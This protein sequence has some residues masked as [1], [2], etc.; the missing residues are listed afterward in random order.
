MTN[1]SNTKAHGNLNSHSKHS[2]HIDLNV[3]VNSHDQNCKLGSVQPDI[4]SRSTRSHAG[5]WGANHEH[6]NGTM[7]PLII[8]LKDVWNSG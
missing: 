2:V 5:V 7:D 8:G 1:V 6:H 4:Q 3:K